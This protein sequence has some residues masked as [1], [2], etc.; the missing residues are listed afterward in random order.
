M[1]DVKCL[2]AVAIASSCDV[3]TLRAREAMA[4]RALL[5]RG[6]QQDVW[7]HEVVVGQSSSAASCHRTQL[8]T[9]PR[10]R[11]VLAGHAS[12][13]SA[14]YPGDWRQRLDESAQC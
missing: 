9:T 1:Q 7:L 3:C 2:P 13:H 8:P 5:V 14:A 11:S 10:H 4:V 6:Y 12:I